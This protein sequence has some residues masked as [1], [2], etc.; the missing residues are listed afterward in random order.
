VT[1]FLD[2][3]KTT[4]LSGMLA[5]EEQPALA[6]QFESGEE[7]LAASDGIERLAIRAIEV[8]RDPSGAAS[9]IAG[10]VKAKQPSAL[11]IE[12][13]GVM[14]FT[15]LHNL[16]LD[17]KL[18][19]LVKLRGVAHCV[20]AERV[21]S[22]LNGV[23]LAARE[24]LAACDMVI[25]RNAGSP[26]ALDRVSRAVRAINPGAPVYSAETE[27]AAG[28]VRQELAYGKRSPI[29]MF[30]LVMAALTVGLFIGKRLLDS[31][32]FP[33]NAVF[34]VFL[35]IILQAF[36]F[37]L[38]G[39]L[40]SSAIQVFVPQSLVERRFPKNLALGMLVAVFS[41]FLLPVCDCAS[42]PVFRSLIRKKA[43]LPVAVTFMAAAPVINPVAIMSTWY[44]FNG[45]PGVAIARV[46]LGVIASVLVGLVFAI[47]RMR[48]NVSLAGGFD[49]A[50][51]GAGIMDYSE[52]LA[53][54]SGFLDKLSAYMRHAQ[55]EFLNVGKYLVIGS[56]AAA[57]LQTLGPDVS[58]APTGLGGAASILFL[59]GMAFA[60]SLCSSSDAAVARTFARQ[61]PA[62]A[63][64]GF[65]V[66]GPMMDIKN[67]VML[68]C[69]FTGK[70]IVRLMAVTGAVCF[71][72]AY[73]YSVWMGVR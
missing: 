61:F 58:A 60:L 52:M 28:V 55:A 51:C 42:I 29:G 21:E 43:P 32:N 47:P 1:G 9:R 18:R 16:L 62:G 22:L 68:S 20:D 26:D 31:L 30:S 23:G 66:F 45:D 15:K 40:L 6:V 14:P 65:L 24:Q 35:G 37:L 71:A 46:A 5:C 38:I 17:D 19:P 10:R 39:T 27:S 53:P 48:A 64:M 11:W 13:N 59:M 69:G 7:E 33:G 36:P 50:V 54:R 56:F 2:S 44:A 73:A 34:S 12:W 4:L 25:A 8:E 57:L 67:A 49:R 41:G 63:V 3:G 72:A 70:F